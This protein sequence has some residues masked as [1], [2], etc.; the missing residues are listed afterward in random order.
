M[1]TEQLDPTQ[2]PAALAEGRG[3]LDKDPGAAAERAR[4]LLAAFP[5]LPDAYRL[6]G[7]ALRRLGEDSAAN[8]AELS[9]IQASGADP[10]LQRAGQALVSDDLATAEGVLRQVLRQRPDDVAAIRMLG[11]V[12]ARA[13]LPVEA[14][15]VFRQALELAPGFEYA[16]LHLA[17]ALNQQSRFGE[18]LAELDRLSHEL[19]DFAEVQSL[20]STIL[21]RTGGY[22][23]AIAIHRRGLAERPDDQELLMSLAYLLH[24]VGEQDEAVATYRRLLELNPGAAEAWWRLSNLKTFAFADDDV[25]AI[26]RASDDRFLAP[27][28]RLY[29]HF[30]L[31][32]ALEDRG[33]DEGAF[34]E[35]EQASAIRAAELQH[36]PQ[37]VTNFVDEAERLFTSEFLAA[38]ADSGFPARDPIFIVGL[39]R[40]GS[41]LVEQILASHPQVEGTAELSDIVTLARSLESDERRASEGAWQRYPGVLADLSA[42]ELSHLGELYL[43]RTRVQ[44]KTDRPRFTDKMT[45]NWAHVGFIKLI[46]PNAKIVDVRRHP[47]AAGWSNFRH[48][49]ARGQE[50]SYDLEHIGAYYRDYV[51]LMRHFD[52]VAP[53]A[54]HRVIHEK[55]VADPEGEIRRLLDYLDLPFDKACLDFHKTKRAVRTPSAE[56][57]RRPISADSAEQWRRF[58]QWLGPLE[59]ALG[60]ALERWED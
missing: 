4:Q 30:A 5:G 44:R 18:A 52:E 34:R 35:Y 57:V 46:L 53:G 16:R 40:A 58:E 47:L 43:E 7:L 1:A 20:R 38:H 41:T 31:G 48:H 21:S 25:G 33:E 9:A 27:L 59:R 8:E 3:L 28:D 19:Q 42:E 29:L 24:T 39:P 23:E 36:Q 17:M 13:G 14:E 49:F 10:A 11:E 6:L 2:I 54:I 12:A 51:R 60:P 37:S 45:I 15:R 50:F 32:K 56:Q 22:D 26:R 55:L